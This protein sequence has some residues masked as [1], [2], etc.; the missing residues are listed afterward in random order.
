MAKR[1]RS[2]HEFI[3][4]LNP[5]AE[6]LEGRRTHNRLFL[7]NDRR[8]DK[9]VVPLVE[10]AKHYGLAIEVAD[11]QQLDRLSDGGNH[12]GVVLET[13]PF[14]YAELDQMVAEGQGRTIIVLDH[15]Q[16]PQNLATLM[17]TA[18]AVDAAGV[19]VQSDRSAQVTPAVVR[20]SAGLVEK[21][22]VA[23]ENNTRRALDYLKEHGY[24]AI[25]LESTGT[26]DNI[27][28]T[29][30]PTPVALVIGSEGK[31]IASNVVNAC[32]LCV[33]LPMPGEA[34]SLNAAVAGSIA[35]YEILRRLDQKDAN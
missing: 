24:W 20:S 2:N 17:R 22:L 9:R 33:E 18:A 6:T 10:R 28:T 14:Q 7:R 31:G 26:S 30:I 25:A 3:Y 4:G 15:V 29:D 23:R 35:L 21:V 34:E 1:R 19:I 16:D 32:D 11:Q 13:G 5:V 8:E 12:Q 27:F